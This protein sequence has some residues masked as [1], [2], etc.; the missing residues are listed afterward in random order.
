MAPA[1]SPARQRDVCR[2][3]LGALALVTMTPE[4]AG[5]V[6]SHQS[7]QL[8]DRQR[9]SCVSVDAE[10]DAKLNDGCGHY[11]A[12]HTERRRSDEG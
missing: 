12:I 6:G 3:L 2:S 1:I 7:L 4:T 9:D 11:G 10:H 8:D 5:Q